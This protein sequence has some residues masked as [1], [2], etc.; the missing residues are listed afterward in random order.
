MAVSQ[1]DIANGLNGFYYG[2]VKLAIAVAG[3]GLI[4]GA[5][6]IANAVGLAIVGRWREL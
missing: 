4:S 3:Y 1:A 5:V 2:L 6:H